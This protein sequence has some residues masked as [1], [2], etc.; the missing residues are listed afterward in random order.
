MAASYLAAVCRK[1]GAVEHAPKCKAAT[2]ISQSRR[3]FSVL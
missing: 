3:N 2:L 1:K